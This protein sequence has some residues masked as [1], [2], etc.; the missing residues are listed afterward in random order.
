[1]GRNIKWFSGII[2]TIILF[3]SVS[4]IAGQCPPYQKLGALLKS[5]AGWQAEK[6]EGMNMTGS[7]MGELA[8]AH[9][10]YS[11]GGKHLEAQIFCGIQWAMGTWAPFASNFQMDSTEEFIKTTTINGFPVGI[12]YHKK[13]RHGA[14]VVCLDKDL[15]ASQMVRGV[16]VLSFENMSWQEALEIAKKF[17]WEGMKKLLKQ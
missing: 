12:N 3:F 5:I 6:C 17:D 7:P 4:L 8:S 11:K 13:D 15:Q 16:F 14:I 10:A 9:R 1:M 2:I